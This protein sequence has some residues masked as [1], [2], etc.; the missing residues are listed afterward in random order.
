LAG[1]L[2]LNWDRVECHLT[3]AE[4][5]RQGVELRGSAVWRPE[6]ELSPGTADSLGKK[7]RAY[8][9]RSGLKAASVLVSVGRD[10]L[11]LKEISHPPLPP[12]EEPALVRFQATKD[13]AESPEA[14]VVD[15]TGLSDQAAAGERQSLA[16]ILRRSILTSFQQLCR[17]AGLKLL[18]VVPRAFAAAGCLQRAQGSRE[19]ETINQALGVGLPAPPHSAVAVLLLGKERWAELNILHG[20]RLLFSRSLGTGPALTAEIRRNLVVF[21]NQPSRPD[22]AFQRPTPQALYVVG[23]GTTPLSVPALQESLNLPVYEVD[24]LTAEEKAV[25]PE[26]ERGSVAAGLGLL[27]AWS[28]RQ[29]PINLASPR[30]PAPVVDQGRRRR[31]L[32]GA[33]AAVVLLAAWFYGQTLLAG[34]RAEIRDLEEQ[35]EQDEARWKKL[36]PER[37][38]LEGLKDWDKGAVRWIDE[39][40]DLDA[41][42]PRADGFRL[43][44]IQV[45]AITQRNQALGKQNPKDEFAARMTIQGVAPPGKEGLVHQFVDSMRDPHLQA[46]VERFR[47]QNFSIRVDL[48]GQAAKK[49]LTRFAPSAARS[50]ERGR[51]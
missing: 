33:A 39:L 14:V 41:R 1:V 4:T 24:F 49:Y 3:A 46:R 48:A 43:T 13:L 10:R 23:T 25:V 44:R 26:E 11:V 38:D 35:R 27:Q 22:G 31:I 47:G 16:V 32:L 45:E 6:E 17:S 5:S 21:A 2:V 15:Y 9:N 34:K 37:N 42:F 29:V 40:Y 8:L 30:E 12:Q 51:P 28:A 19:R 50:T 18:G 36:E 20:T 7:L